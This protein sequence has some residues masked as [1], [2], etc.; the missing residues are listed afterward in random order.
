[1]V[2]GTGASKLCLNTTTEMSEYG[3]VGRVGIRAVGTAFW[4]PFGAFWVPFLQATATKPYRK[5]DEPE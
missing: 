2:S 4:V 3:A 1:M 5:A